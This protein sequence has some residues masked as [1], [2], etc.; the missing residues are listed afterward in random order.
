VCTASFSAPDRRDMLGEVLYHEC[1]RCPVP[2]GG[3]A[4][5]HDNDHTSLSPP[6]PALPRMR[7]VSTHTP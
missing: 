2:L 1:G 4:L 7:E 5:Q 3:L 6:L